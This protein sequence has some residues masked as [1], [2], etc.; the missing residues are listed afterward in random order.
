MSIAP[1]PGGNTMVF[2][3]KD[4]NA[5]G[6]INTSTHAI[7]TVALPGGAVSPEDIVQGSDGNDYFVDL[8]ASSGGVEQ[9]GEITSS[10]TITQTALKSGSSPD[11]GGGYNEAAASSNGVVW[12]NDDGNRDLVEYNLS[13][14]AVT[15]FWVP[16]D[17]SYVHGLTLAADGTLWFTEGNTGEVAQLTSTSP[18]TITEYTTSPSAGE[19]S[20]ITQGPDGNIWFPDGT[21][22]DIYELASGATTTRSYTFDADTNRTGLATTVPTTAYACDYTSSSCATYTNGAEKCTSSPAQCVTTQNNS[23]D[24]ADRLND[25]ATA[26]DPFGDVTS[27]PAQDAGGTALTASYYSDGTDDTLTQGSST[28]ITNNLDPDERISEQVTSNPST[29][30]TTDDLDNYYDSDSDSPAYTYDNTTSTWTRNIPDIT[31]NIAAIWTTHAG[32]NTMTYQLT[33]LQG[34]IVATA[35]SS[36]S[37]TGLQSVTPVTEYGVPTTSTPAK[38]SWLGGK[39]RQ[40]ELASGIVAMGARVYDPYTGTFL[41]TDP[42]PGADPNAYGY[43]AGDPV[44]E[45]D[46]SGDFWI[47]SGR[48]RILACM[49]AGCIAHGVAP[50]PYGAATPSKNPNSPAQHA[51]QTPGQTAHPDED[52][53]TGVNGDIGVVPDPGETRVVRSSPSGQSFWQQL[54]DIS[55]VPA[56]ENIGRSYLSLWSTALSTPRPPG[57]TT[58]DFGPEA[59]A[60]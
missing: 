45:T 8:S 55:P 31:G 33:N 36:T 16:S 27:M 60:P 21:T 4:G 23:Y 50:A 5:I 59:L 57:P 2:T 24:Q 10:G 29:H 14:H 22:N 49:V 52:G 18:E 58:P 28:E 25:T 48:K 7:T 39:T 26:Y 51:P 20:G 41:Q 9:I 13:S 15:Y 34:S 46:L 42:I 1:G 37:A 17:M 54:Y 43:T 56:L 38:Y 44:N 11:P 30:A 40:T 6:T 53:D 35:S 32:T 3:E 47:Q 12:F 19:T